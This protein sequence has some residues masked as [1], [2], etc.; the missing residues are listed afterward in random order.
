LVIIDGLD[1]LADWDPAA[2]LFLGAAVA[3]V[4]AFDAPALERALQAS[5]AEVV[6]DE[7]TALPRHPSEMSVIR[8]C[9]DVCAREVP[10]AHSGIE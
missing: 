9:A 3:Q 5:G 7:L 2:D 1:G 8:Q 10:P 6:I 4:N